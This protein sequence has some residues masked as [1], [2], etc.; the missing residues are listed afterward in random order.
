VNEKPAL[1]LTVLRKVLLST[2][3]HEA[4]VCGAVAGI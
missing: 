2:S 1:E 3:T 4:K